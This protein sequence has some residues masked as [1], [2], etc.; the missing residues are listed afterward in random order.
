MEHKVQVQRTHRCRTNP[1]HLSP[2]SRVDSFLCIR[3]GNT[4]VSVMHHFFLCLFIT[5]LKYQK[6]GKKFKFHM[7]QY[8]LFT[9]RRLLLTSV[10]ISCFP[11]HWNHLLF[12]N[13]FPFLWFYRCFVLQCSFSYTLCRISAVLISSYFPCW[14]WNGKKKLITTA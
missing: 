14:V 9:V 11:L 12:L 6:V 3:H 4:L 10:D 13:L 8:E 7:I 2:I 1:L 5:S